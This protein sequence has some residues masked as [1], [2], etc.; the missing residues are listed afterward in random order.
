MPK[1]TAH[2]WLNKK[3]LTIPEFC[4][5]TGIDFVDAERWFRGGIKTPLTALKKIRAVFPDFPGYG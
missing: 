5:K 1:L 4:A 2:T 3:G